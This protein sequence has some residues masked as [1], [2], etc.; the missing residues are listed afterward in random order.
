[1]DFLPLNKYSKLQV[2]WLKCGGAVDRIVEQFFPDSGKSKSLGGKNKVRN[3]LGNY[4]LLATIL[5]SR[6]LKTS[7][8]CHWKFEEV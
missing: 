3:A 6:S 1:M 2:Y 5:T 7:K 4:R 8:D